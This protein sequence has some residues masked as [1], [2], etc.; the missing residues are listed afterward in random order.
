MPIS[1][2]TATRLN[3]L[4]RPADGISNYAIYAGILGAVVDEPS[5]AARI[6]ALAY[7]FA[8]K[9]FARWSG[10]ETPASEYPPK[11]DFEGRDKAAFEALE[12]DRQFPRQLIA[13][14]AQVSADEVDV[15]ERARR[16]WV[17]L[18][19]Q[20]STPLAKV[21]A[22]S[23]MLQDGSPFLEAATPVRDEA[24]FNEEIADDEYRGILWRNRAVIAKLI[25]IRESDAL[26][27]KTATGAAV[28]DAISEIRDGRER[29]AIL[30]HYLGGRGGIGL[31]ALALALPS[32]GS[33]LD[34]LR[35][36]AER[37]RTAAEKGEPCPSCGKVHGQGEHEEGKGK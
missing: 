15:P 12:Q 25:G 16:A 10:P 4:M 5:E 23:A 36:A 1:E 31:H 19:K 28:L 7:V 2:R 32:A 14:G 17:F 29:A 33:I 21:T 18:A 30:G 3:A 20:C 24:R 9:T 8:N 27:T 6:E 35:A 26:K 34:A 37:V 22:L 13:F 11:P